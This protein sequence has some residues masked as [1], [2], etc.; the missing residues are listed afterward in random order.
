MRIALHRVAP[1]LVV[2][3]S[4]VATRPAEARAG[5]AHAAKVV[6]AKPAKAKK[7]AASKKP[8]KATLLNKAPRKKGSLPGEPDDDKRASIAGETPKDAEA[9]PIELQEIREVDDELFPEVFGD[10][11][12]TVGKQESRVVANGL[13]PSTEPAP[14]SASTSSDYGWMASLEK[15]DIPFRWDGRLVRYLDY[16]KN[17]PKGRAFARA[18]V[19]KAGRYEAKIRAA[20]KAKGMPEDV[21]WLALV[22]SGMNPKIGSPAGAA[23]LWQFMPK[24]ATAYGLRV[25]KWV[26]E[27]LDPERSTEAALRYLGDLH[28]RFGRWELA[29]AAYN[30]GHGGLLTAIR[31]YNTND[32][33]E[34]S[35]LEAG[36]PFETALYV[37]KIVALAFVSR[38]KAVFACDDVV[39]DPPEAF[40]V[41]AVGPGVTLE[42]VAGAASTDKKALAELNPSLVGSATPPAPASA[43]TGP[44]GEGRGSTFTV[45]VPAGKKADVESKLASAPAGPVDDYTLRWGESLELVAAEHGTT[46]SKLR[47]MNGLDDPTPPRPGTTI[48]VP[49]GRAAAPIETPVAVVPSRVEPVP[50]RDRVFYEVVWGDQLADVA[51]ALGVSED[52]LC[53]WNNLD[54]DARLHGKMVLQAFVPAGQKLADVRV[55]REKET[56]VLAVGSEE[57]FD[58]FESKNGR[59]RIV[60][61]VAEGDTL[62]SLAA[63]YA[64]TIGMMERINHRARTAAL[65]PGEKLVVYTKAGATKGAAKGAPVAAFAGSKAD[66]PER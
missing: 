65:V 58:W 24:A 21:V 11:A 27:R 59:T 61:T 50:G 34:L 10:A 22:E 53:H 62:K 38:N 63:K 4:L 3:A 35:E 60:V 17:D 13:P 1:A 36:V 5:K 45:K 9:E 39:P 28:T 25:D 29:F 47:A 31:K 51:H 44:L 15:P 49:R 46:E 26:D 16:F 32:F 56:K 2:L 52:D 7:P 43:K 57:F 20:A 40:D 12:T 19:K 42:S 55:A 64:L 14:S 41:A 8:G 18:L 30:M 54:R 33:W 23:G 48:V 37:P 6:A 66:D